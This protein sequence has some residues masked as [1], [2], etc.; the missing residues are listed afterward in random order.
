[1]SG[2]A[3]FFFGNPWGLLALASAAVVVAAYLFYQR[4]RPIR[5]TGLFLWGIPQR[6]LRGGRHLEPPRFSRSFWLD[7]LAALLFALA[8]AAPMK[9][10]RAERLPVVILDDSFSM[11]AQGNDREARLLAQLLLSGAEGV[12]AVILAGERPELLLPPGAPMQR[13]QALLSR[14]LPA[15]KMSDPRAAL[16][17]AQTLF[18]RRLDVH[19]LTDHPVE[20]TP[21]EGDTFTLHELA[22]RGGNL[23][24]TGL[25]RE[26]QK[27][28]EI[29][30]ARVVNYSPA[31]A[32]VEFSLSEVTPEEGAATEAGGVFRKRLRLAPG[33]SAA[34][35]TM[36]SQAA[37]ILRAELKPLTGEDVIAADSVGFL[38]PPPLRPVDYALEG[39]DPEA[40]RF[41]RLGLNAAGAVELPAGAGR[42]ALLITSN[43]NKNGRALTLELLPPVYPATFS[44]PFIIDLASPVCR[45]VHPGLGYWTAATDKPALPASGW[46]IAAGRHPLFWRTGEDH[47]TLNLVPQK[48]SIVM[49]PAWPALLLNLTTEARENLPGLTKT[50]YYPAEALGYRPAR[51]RKPLLKKPSNA[52]SASGASADL[53][54]AKLVA[55]IAARET[56]AVGSDEAAGMEEGA[57]S[58]D[59]DLQLFYGNE[60]IASVAQTGLLR[61]PY[62]SGLYA[63]RTQ[64]QLA[65]A[66]SVLPLYDAEADTRELSA[67]AQERILTGGGGALQEVAAQLFWLPL[68]LGMLL[69]LLNWLLGENG[70]LRAA[71]REGKR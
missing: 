39:I 60:L 63:L 66:L 30:C 24:F 8:L 69:L 57:E 61:L 12:G 36:V 70:A 54:S 2:I 29:V 20:L 59:A 68:V 23:A 67:T 58:R 4:Y 40:A 32:E 18:A 28:R 22:G 56:A 50:A 47:Y 62:R 6:S 16:K 35:E 10:W 45:D 42:P 25:W 14:Y 71:G 7:L 44:P 1:M 65:G 51:S 34:C 9:L 41:L 46:L 21:R 19:L 33:G 53:D 5:A 15:Q 38:P 3:G 48:S 11:Q 17:L 64:G 43:P 26:W 13:A 27:E 49:S 55:P 52:S 31:E 37:G